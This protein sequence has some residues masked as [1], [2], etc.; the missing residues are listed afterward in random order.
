MNTKNMPPEKH[1]ELIPPDSTVS[2]IMKA[3]YIRNGSPVHKV[4]GS[5][6]YTL[7]RR[8][9]VLNSDGSSG[10]FFDGLFLTDNSSYINSIDPDTL[11]V[12]PTTPTLLV[13]EIDLRMD[14][15]DEE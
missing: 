14:Y 13:N 2:I 1:H 6:I 9:S 10:Q 5:K 3:R 4:T 7:Q 11:L 12:M 15:S 8:I